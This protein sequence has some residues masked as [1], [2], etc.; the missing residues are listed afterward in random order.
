MEQIS[1]LP[2]RSTSARKL[3]SLT[4]AGAVVSGLLGAGFWLANR[5]PK[6]AEGDDCEGEVN[7]AVEEEQKWRIDTTWR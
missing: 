1:P 7:R 5:K 4:V 3:S 2:P 6:V